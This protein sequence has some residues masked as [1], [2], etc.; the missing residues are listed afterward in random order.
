MVQPPRSRSRPR[1]RSSRLDGWRLAPSGARAR[2]DR[3]GSRTRGSSASASTTA[4]AT[5]HGRRSKI[6]ATSFSTNAAWTSRTTASAPPMARSH[7]PAVGA[8][9]APQAIGLA[10]RCTPAATTN[11]SASGTASTMSSALKNH[12]LTEEAVGD[13]AD[14]DGEDRGDDQDPDLHRLEA[15]TARAAH[16]PIVRRRVDCE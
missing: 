7:A 14:A 5:H 3:R 8:T 11:G 12:L 4:R 6:P 9:S 2:A 10:R 1:F 15:G 16:L 13:R